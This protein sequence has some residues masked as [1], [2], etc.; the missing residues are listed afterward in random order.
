MLLTLLTR[1]QTRT[2]KLFVNQDLMCFTIG[3]KFI[4]IYWTFKLNPFGMLIA[5]RK[6]VAHWKPVAN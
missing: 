2:H 3:V 5:H 6:P 1:T 4:T